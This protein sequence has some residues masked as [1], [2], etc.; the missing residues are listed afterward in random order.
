M[1]LDLFD[2]TN[3][4]YLLVDLFRAYFDARKNK[5]NTINA[6]SFEL[7][8]ERNLFELYDEIVA[9]AYEPKPS[10]CF[11][12]N[13]PV[14]REI[15]AADFRDRVVH[16]LL[17]NY[18]AGIFDNTFINDS[19]SCRKLKGTHYAIKRVD[20]F[21]R[22]C[23]LNYSVDCYILKLDIKGYFMA[24]NKELLCRKIEATLARK[25]SRIR[26]DRELLQELINKTIFCDPANNC[27]IKCKS[28]DWDELPITKSLFHSS[29]G[30]G[31]PIGNLTSQLF[32]NIYLN[33]FD[34]FVKREL[35][36]RY[37]GRY[38]D[39]IILVHRDREHLKRCI[40]KIRKKLK[41]EYKLEL[42]PDKIYLQ[43]YSKGVKYLGVMIKPRR[44]YIARR[45]KG[46]FYEAIIKHNVIAEKRVPS[47]KER[48]EFVSTMNSYLGLLR[49]YKTFK[50]RKMMFK[51]RLSPEWWK[52]VH[53]NC[54]FT[55]VT[56]RP[57][58]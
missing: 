49:H 35:C 16:H 53:T 58:A 7:H 9:H 34:H 30:C 20:H 27:I 41:H 22:S 21:I 50:M 39:D 38:V 37:Y 25:W 26:C 51:N 24:M 3:T 42:H 45:T 8:F 56:K 5:R 10:I 52:Y 43:H 54:E 4:D 36:I 13:K 31:L 19:Y 1:Q 57:L 46:N 40:P 44:I 29:E 33:E 48:K 11:I 18:I 28:G 12:V 6:L 23:S 17:Y 47:D 15:F 2:T 32:A 55:K 14:K